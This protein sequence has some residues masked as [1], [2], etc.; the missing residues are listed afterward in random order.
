MRVAGDRIGDV[1]VESIHANGHVH[2]MA[3][4]RDAGEIAKFDV[5]PVDADLVP[6][7]Q[8]AGRQALFVISKDAH[9]G[10][11]VPRDGVVIDQGVRDAVGDHDAVLVGKGGVFK[12]IEADDVVHDSVVVRQDVG[13][14]R[15]EGHGDLVAGD[16]IGRECPLAADEV[17]VARDHDAQC[18]AQ[19]RALLEVGAD[20]IAFDDVSRSFADEDAGDGVAADDI[21]CVYDILADL[22]VVARDEDACAAWLQDAVGGNADVVVADDVVVS[23]D[24]NARL[25]V[26]ECIGVAGGRADLVVVAL[27]VY[28]DKSAGKGQ[29]QDRASF[30]HVE[31]EQRIRQGDLAV[32]VQGGTIREFELIEQFDRSGNAER[33]IHR[34]VHVESF[35]EGRA[36]RAPTQFIAADPVLRFVHGRIR[37][38]IRVGLQVVGQGVDREIELRHAISGEQYDE[39]EGS[40]Y[41]EQYHVFH[42]AGFEPK[43]TLFG[44]HPVRSLAVRTALFKVLVRFPQSRRLCRGGAEGR[45]HRT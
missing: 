36:H 1:L 30:I 21:R 43:F 3:E 44:E 14:G 39:E 34:L 19:A 7:D 37:V 8:V 11:C 24:R 41:G 13:R 22:V 28:A 20:G 16:D 5:V 42:A 32:A 17:V 2:D 31:D 15:L 9:A 29:A 4:K 40:V 33:H 18:I 35:L 10:A 27:D 45:G 12:L 23:A 6:V 26:E 38:I 25:A